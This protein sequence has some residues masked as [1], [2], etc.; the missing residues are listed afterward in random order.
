MKYTVLPKNC[1]VPKPRLEDPSITRIRK[2]MF[3]AKSHV[4]KQAIYLTVEK[5]N[6]ESKLV[7]VEK[8]HAHLVLLRYPCYDCEGN[9][10]QFL[11]T[12]VSF[13]S[14]FCGDEKLKYL[15]DEDI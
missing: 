7:V 9:F 5:R 10:R 4:G 14:L 1:K 3:E 12:S 15:D 13:F 2:L 6:T 11:R 8:V